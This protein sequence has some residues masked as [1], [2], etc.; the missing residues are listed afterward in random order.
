LFDIPKT[1]G[2]SAVYDM[3]IIK[4]S[5]SAGPLDRN[6]QRSEVQMTTSNA[7][8]SLSMS[9]NQLIGTISAETE[10]DLHS[11]SFRSSIYST[12]IEK[13]N[14][15]TN[16]QVEY[17][18]DVTL[19]SLIGI[20]TSLNETFDKYETEGN[21]SG[22][23]P[24][25]SVEALRGT[26]WIDAH[27]YP[28]VYE[29][30]GNTGITLNRNTNDLGIIPLKAM[31]IFNSGEKGYL[32]NGQ[33]GESKTGDVC[34]R[35]FVPHYVYADFSELRN[36]AASMYLGQTGIPPQA[37]RLLE[38]SINDISRGNYPFRISYRLPGLNTIT[39]SRDLNI[40]Y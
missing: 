3:T 8:D 37:Q 33:T 12:F 5:I 28:Q 18:I 24:M 40:I 1:L 11:L 36:K 35:Y 22:I 6:L 23:E 15:M 9:K 10:T 26:P 14:S 16:S 32:L 31:I 38:G 2:S 25:V 13:L 7:T 4:K 21:G 39:T 19:M 20:K 29:L 34:I 27:V 17:A 30:Y